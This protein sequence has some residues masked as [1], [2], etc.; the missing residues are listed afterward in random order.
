MQARGELPLKWSCHFKAGV[1]Y[2]HLN[3]KVEIEG[4]TPLCFHLPLS[5][6]SAPPAAHHSFV[7]ISSRFNVLENSYAFLGR[8]FSSKMIYLKNPQPQFCD[9]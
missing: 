7:S 2:S 1:I 9:Y 3:G 6:A 5:S 8:N 4:E